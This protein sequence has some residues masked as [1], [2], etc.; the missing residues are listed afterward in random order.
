M[1][2]SLTGTVREKTK[3]TIVIQTN[4][5]VGYAVRVGV[6]VGGTKGQLIELYTYLKVSDQAMEL[7]GFLT[8]EERSFF[9][10]LLLVSGVGPKTAM[11]ILSLGSID[12]I[13]DA[14]SRG[15][16]AYLSAVQGIGKKTAERMVV[17]L[18]SKVKS[19]GWRTSVGGDTSL[20]SALE[21]VV[22][23]LVGMGYTLDQAREAVRGLECE[24]KTTEELLREA[25]RRK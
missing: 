9:E 1:I 7:Y 24:G 3:D 14:I 5:G 17:E 4:G 25:L 15:D 2:S 18:K 22:D 19:V 8:T 16:A 6:H 23:G 11:N 13:Q 10:L 20:G 12:D 21:E